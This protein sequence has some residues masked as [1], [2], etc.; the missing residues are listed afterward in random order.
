[1]QSNTF[2][3]IVFNYFKVINSY[4]V[5]WEKSRFDSNAGLPRSDVCTHE[6][7]SRFLS[8]K[9]FRRLGHLLYMSFNCLCV[10][11]EFWEDDSWGHLS[12][13]EIPELRVCH[14]HDDG[15][16]RDRADCPVNH[17]EVF[18][19]VEVKFCGNLEPPYL[20]LQLWP[21]SLVAGPIHVYV[22][23]GPSSW[24]GADSPGEQSTHYSEWRGQRS[25]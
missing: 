12:R 18:H 5:K 22:V 1:M 6:P 7:I 25:P 16:F 10:A 3:I 8:T 21:S 4:M 15:R 17:V 2:I 11:G 9:R 20:S 23:D 13:D 19:G 24:P 14:C